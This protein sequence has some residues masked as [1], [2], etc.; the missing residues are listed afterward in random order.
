M[1]TPE[2]YAELAIEKLQN[3]TRV[4]VLDIELTDTKP[5]IFESKV[6]GVPYLPKDMEIPLD[7]NGK[8]M[9]L[10][11]Q[12]NCK[13]LEPLEDYPHSGI[14]QFWLTTEWPWETDNFAVKY[15]RDI[16][17]TLTESDVIPRIAE[18]IEGE[19]GTF[20]VNGEYGMKFYPG[21][22]TMGRDDERLEALFCQY[23]SEIS[24][25]IMYTPEDEGDEA[26]G[27]YEDYRDDAYNFGTKIGGYPASAQLVDYLSYRPQN[28]DRSLNWSKYRN[29]VSHID[30]QS[31]DEEFVLFQLDSD[32]HNSKDYRVLW[33][34]VGVA[35]F[36]ITRRDLKAGNLENVSFYWD[37]S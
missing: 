37:C 2:E 16:D 5:S 3:E 1:P 6:G 23:Y 31:D 26:Y 25:E 34:D 29:Y 7:K 8:Q 35:H 36:K 12:I 30:M 28:Y 9:K 19:T 13:D 33:C 17:D 11:A 21:E 10:L 14:L 22:E 27:V 15:H 18:F 20:P 32:Y 24:G 4:P